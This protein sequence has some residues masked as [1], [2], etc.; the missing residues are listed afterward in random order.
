MVCREEIK[1]NIDAVDL[2]IHSQFVILAQYDLHLAHSME[3]G[4]NYQAL[5]FATKLVQRFCTDLENL[6]VRLPEVH[7]KKSN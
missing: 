3:N 5:L 4:I 1:Y 7:S 2:L 6:V